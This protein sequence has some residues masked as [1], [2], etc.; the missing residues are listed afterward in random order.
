MS[1]NNGTGRHISSPR[2]DSHGLPEGGLVSVVILCYNQARFLGDAIESVLSQTYEDFEVVVVDDGSEDHTSEVASGY[3]AKDP[4]VRLIR[5]ENRK[6]AGA[7]NISLLSCAR[8]L[9]GVWRRST[10]RRRSA[11]R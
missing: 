6:L 5:Q 1:E 2:P 4:R 7:R 9:G 10:H 8:R 3:A 11:R